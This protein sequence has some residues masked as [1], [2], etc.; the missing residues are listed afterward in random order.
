MNEP[1]LSD[2]QWQLVRSAIVAQ[3]HNTPK[4]TEKS[5]ELRQLMKVLN[6]YYYD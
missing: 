6:I 3:F 4:E 2:N 5:N 1:K